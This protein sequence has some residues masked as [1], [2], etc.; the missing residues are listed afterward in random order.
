MFTV[1]KKQLAEKLQNFQSNLIK[2]IN[3][4]ES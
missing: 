2:Y 4:S 1:S 3:S